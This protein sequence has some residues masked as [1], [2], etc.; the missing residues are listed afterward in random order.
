[1]KPSNSHPQTTSRRSDQ[2]EGVPKRHRGAASRFASTGI[3]LAWL[4][5]PRR[6]EPTD[7]GTNLP[8]TFAA[9]SWFWHLLTVMAAIICAGCRVMP[10]QQRCCYGHPPP[11][12]ACC[13]RVAAVRWPLPECSG[14][15]ADR[16]LDDVVTAIKALF[17][18][19]KIYKIAIVPFSFVFDKYC[20]IID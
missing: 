16:A 7:S 6:L 4:G 3:A 2:A 13:L 18:F 5:H 12:P 17:T 9:T 8:P 15:L 1:M 10:S 11:R 14:W 19:K 20:P